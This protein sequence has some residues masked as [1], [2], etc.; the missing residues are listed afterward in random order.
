MSDSKTQEEPEGATVEFDM[1]LLTPTRAKKATTAA[2]EAL[3]GLTRRPLRGGNVNFWKGVMRAVPVTTSQR[4]AIAVTFTVENTEVPGLLLVERRLAVTVVNCMIGEERDST[5]D[6][7]ED[8]HRSVLAEALGGVASTLQESLTSQFGASV[9]VS[10]SPGVFEADQVTLDSATC[11]YAGVEL[12][13]GVESAGW[14]GVVVSEAPLAA[15]M[16][17][18]T[19]AKAPPAS[20]TPS[21]FPASH[22]P[23]L[24]NRPEG[25]GEIPQ[26][27]G[28]LLDV[29]MQLV[30]VLGRRSMKLREVLQMGAGSV[31]ELDKLAGE[32]LELLIN[33]KLIGYGEVIVADDK[34][35][36]KVRDVVN[37]EDRLRSARL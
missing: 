32:P 34:F 27:L 25:S 10:A 5:L 20:T 24:S 36:I 31:L 8:L 30:A 7:F 12:I 6:A 21:G 13:D 9:Q 11:V 15:L 19:T 23:Q 16:A 29:P 3:A 4:V 33:G 17:R 37:A 35:G 28:L 2:A 14:L 1:S 22:F 26:N 18:L